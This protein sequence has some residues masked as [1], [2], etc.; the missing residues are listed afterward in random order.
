MIVASANRWA[1]FLAFLCPCAVTILGLVLLPMSR[2]TPQ[3]DGNAAPAPKMGPEPLS[4]G[5]PRPEDP[6]RLTIRVAAPKRRYRPME[7]IPLDIVVS[8]VSE[9]EMVRI[10]MHLATYPTVQIVVRDSEG[11]E[12]PKTRRG[13]FMFM[14]GAYSTFALKPGAT[15][16]PKLLANLVNDMTEDEEYTIVVKVP[17]WSNA[18]KQVNRMLVSE[19]I[20]VRVEGE[21]FLGR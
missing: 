19:P 3:V 21:P 12:V 18:N 13:K 17:Y 14:W 1:R 7:P 11:M 10:H 8:N 2:A 15:F 4:F 20:T 6:A 5:P 9:A 16:K